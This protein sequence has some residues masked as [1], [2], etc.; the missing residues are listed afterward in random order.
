[1]RAYEVLVVFFRVRVRRV[2]WCKFGVRTG[3]VNQINYGL[4]PPLFPIRTTR[5][6]PTKEEY[7][8]S[9]SIG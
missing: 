4:R 5:T 9:R 7:G 1:M 8:G 3:G 2:R 6:R